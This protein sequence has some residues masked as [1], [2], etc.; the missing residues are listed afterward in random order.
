[1]P[2]LTVV[3]HFLQRECVRRGMD[4]SFQLV[5]QSAAKRPDETASVTQAAPGLGNKVGRRGFTVG[6]RDTCN[7]HVFGGRAVK[8]RCK[9]P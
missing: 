7:Q 8:Y 2:T 5:H 6:A 4:A 1:M 9:F 3:E